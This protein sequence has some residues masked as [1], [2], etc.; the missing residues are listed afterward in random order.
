MIFFWRKTLL[1]NLWSQGFCCESE[2]HCYLT[3]SYP[4]QN[5]CGMACIKHCECQ[6]SMPQEGGGPSMSIKKE[7]IWVSAFTAFLQNWSGKANCMLFNPSVC[8]L[9]EEDSNKSQ[10]CVV[11]LLKCLS[12][13]TDKTIFKYH[14]KIISCFLLFCILYT[15]MFQF[16]YTYVCAYNLLSI[17]QKISLGRYWLKAI[18]EITPFQWRR[19]PVAFIPQDYHILLWLW[20]LGYVE[21]EGGRVLVW[22]SCVCLCLK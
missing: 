2:S 19:H 15:H 20:G 3:D 10:A 17:F 4:R 1:R 18:G 6:P 21:W 9:S 11:L 12:Y 16:I 14:A 13:P 5:C 22:H 8:P 7:N